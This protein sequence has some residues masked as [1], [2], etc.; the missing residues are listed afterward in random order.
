MSLSGSPGRMLTCVRKIAPVVALKGAQGRQYESISDN[1]RYRLSD[2][3]DLPGVS[4]ESGDC[5]CDR[6]LLKVSLTEHPVSS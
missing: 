1:D 6:L 3:G 2:I 5:S 4:K